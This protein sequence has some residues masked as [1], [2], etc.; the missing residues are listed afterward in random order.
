MKQECLVIPVVSSV[1]FKNVLEKL[2]ADAVIAEGM[3]AGG[4]IGKLTTMTLVRQV[5]D[6][7]ITV[8]VNCCCWRRTVLQQSLCLVEAIQVGTRFAVSKESNA[9]Q[10]FKDKILK[11]KNIDTV[12][13]AS[14]LD[15]QFVLSKIN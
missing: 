9:H 8:I 13:S 6:G 1:I 3:E 11:A 14:V 15:T 2:G 5:V 7:N 4:H 12:I 10:N